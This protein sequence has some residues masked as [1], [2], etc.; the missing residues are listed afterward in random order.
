MELGTFY[1]HSVDRSFIRK[2]TGTS[3]SY[4]FPS[5]LIGGNITQPEL[6]A[7]KSSLTVARTLAKETRLE[8][9][10]RARQMR[11]IMA[12]VGLESHL[13]L[14]L[15]GCL[16][17]V[18]F[19]FAAG[20]TWHLLRFHRR[21]SPLEDTDPRAAAR[22]PRLPR[23]AGLRHAQLLLADGGVAGGRGP[24]EVAYIEVI[25][26]RII[27]D[28]LRAYIWEGVALDAPSMGTNKMCR[29]CYN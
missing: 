25:D 28:R 9:C 16:N 24:F 21:I 26:A 10:K 18:V 22:P 27:V 11:S 23:R 5:D 7:V 13:A 29:V 3:F 19:I 4:P 17:A 20:F 2:G 8:A 12:D 1:L 15:S 14:L 6:E